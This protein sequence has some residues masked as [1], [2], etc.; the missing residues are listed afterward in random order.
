MNPKYIITLQCDI[1]KERCSGYLCEEAFYNREGGFS[2]Y[3]KDADSRYLSF[4]CGG[5]CGRASLRKLANALK[6]LKK[7]AGIDT[8]GVVVH[9]SSCMCR[10]SF[11][12]PKCPHF[13][14]IQ[15]L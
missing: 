11:H 9:Y 2:G 6:L 14:Y 8:G 5:C 7:R 1:V 3:S 13:D 4:S 12:G 10:E 15:E